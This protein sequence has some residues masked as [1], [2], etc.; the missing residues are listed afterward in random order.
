[1]T[2]KLFYKILL[3]VIVLTITAYY[4]YFPSL[5][6]LPNMQCIFNKTTGLHCPGCGGQRA[7]HALLHGQVAYAAQN[8]FLIFLV[9]PVAGLKLAEELSGKKIFPAVFYSRKVV[10]SILVLVILFSVLRNIPIEPFSYLIPPS[11]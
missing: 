3:A 8:N 7:F 1:M 11:I 4:F 2:H 9:L 6:F 5:G 10:L